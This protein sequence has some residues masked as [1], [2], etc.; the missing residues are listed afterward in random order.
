VK[1][2]PNTTGRIDNLDVLRAL[3]ALAVCLYHFRRGPLF[4][5]SVYQELAFYGLHGVDIFFVISVMS[6]L[7]PCGGAGSA[8]ATPVVSGLRGLSGSILPTCLPPC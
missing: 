2:K 8:I 6:S 3:A 5:G 4:E 7:W 1:T